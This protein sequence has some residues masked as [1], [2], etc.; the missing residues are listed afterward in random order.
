M[1]P[2]HEVGTPWHRTASKHGHIF[3]LSGLR[4]PWN[5]QLFM[6][7][8]S[9]YIRILPNSIT[10]MQFPQCQHLA[11][12]SILP[13]INC[14]CW[15]TILAYHLP[16]VDWTSLSYIIVIFS[17]ITEWGHSAHD[18]CAGFKTIPISSFYCLLFPCHPFSFTCPSTDSPSIQLYVGSFWV[19][20]PPSCWQSLG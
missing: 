13:P 6:V 20:N 1:V 15:C 4:P 2:R 8:L 17:K 11:T 18:V 10:S 7:G 14:V 3:I 9:V 12:F 5:L 19:D 16:S